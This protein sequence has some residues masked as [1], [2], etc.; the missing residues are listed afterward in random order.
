MPVVDKRV[1]AYIANAAPFA[2]PVLTHFRSLIHKADPDVVET[3]KWGFPNFESHGAVVCSMAAFKQ[4]CT[5]GFWKASLMKD[6]NKILAIGEKASMGHLGRIE[7]LKDLP[8]DKILISYIKEAVK[9]NAD[10]VK[11]A[12]KEKSK[13][14]APVEIPEVVKKALKKNARALKVFEAFSPSHRKEYIEWISEAKTETTRDKRIATMIEWLEEGK[15][16][17]WKYQK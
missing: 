4:H 12:R 2:Q 14:I 10:G 3:I 9:L 6:P 15:S 7:T 17:N 16:R 11:V 8:A 13:T 1:D 5:F